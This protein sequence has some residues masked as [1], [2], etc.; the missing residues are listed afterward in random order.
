VRVSGFEAVANIDGGTLVDV[1]G[2]RVNVDI[3]GAAT[4]NGDVFGSWVQIDDDAGAAGTVYGYYLNEQTGVD[5]GFYQNGTA[6]NHLGGKTSIG[7]TVVPLAQTH[8]DQSSA[9]GAIPVLTL[10]QG[11]V[12]EQCIN[13]RSDGVDRDI[14]LWTVEVTGTPT[15][16]WDESADSM[17]YSVQTAATATTIDLLTLTHTTSNTA[18][19]DFGTG[20]LFRLEDATFAAIDAGRM[21]VVW[22]SAAAAESAEYQLWLARSGTLYDVAVIV[23]TSSSVILGNQRGDGAID[24][25]C[26]RDAAT[27]VASGDNATIIGG[28]K[29]TASGNWSTCIGG[30]TNVASGLAAYAAGYTASATHNYSFVFSATNAATVSWAANTFTVR[31]QGGARFYSAAGILT[32]VQ[33]TAGG[34]A[35]AA[36]STRAAK[37]NFKSPDGILDKVVSLPIYDYNL[38]TQDD[39]VRHIGPVAEDF[40]TTFGFTEA[41]SYING[42]DVGGVALAAIQELTAE[43]YTLRERINELERGLIQ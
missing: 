22:K 7:G 2:V 31:S 30:F 24:F 21:S 17:I 27:Q 39:T 12:S 16:M 33:L 38:K 35:W 10:D 34:N 37:E 5:Y 3:E 6:D 25:Q 9:S 4:V 13:F 15:W 42:M 23:H 19:A 20:I 43:V 41:P 36:I 40:N 26:E 14:N 32:G 29:N 11:D 8:I 1:I 28:D 18:A